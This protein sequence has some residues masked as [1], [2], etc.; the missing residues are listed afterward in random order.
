MLKSFKD[1][2]K[3]KDENPVEKPS[4]FPDRGKEVE[5]MHQKVAYYKRY[6]P[7]DAHSLFSPASG[8]YIPASIHVGSNWNQAHVQNAYKKLRDMHPDLVNKS[9]EITNGIAGHISLS[10]VGYPDDYGHHKY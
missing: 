1:F 4:R 8:D 10:R 6:H 5:W 2:F 7:D 9:K 3:K